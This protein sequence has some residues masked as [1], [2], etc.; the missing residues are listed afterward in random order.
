M[1]TILHRN[2]KNGSNNND[3]NIFILLGSLY[4]YDGNHIM[5]HN[6]ILSV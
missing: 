4:Y 5:N 1:Y 6:I 2:I 3:C